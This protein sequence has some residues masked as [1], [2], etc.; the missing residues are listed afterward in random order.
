MVNDQNFRCEKPECGAVIDFRDQVKMLGERA[1]DV[2]FDAWNQPVYSIR[3][4][5]G[6]SS[7]VHGATVMA[8]HLLR[9]AATAVV[10]KEPL[11]LPADMLLQD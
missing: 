10:R 2:T 7:S 9:A 6:H 5:N 11:V 8:S 1:M 4:E 3:C